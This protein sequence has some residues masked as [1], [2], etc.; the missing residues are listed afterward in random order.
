MQIL[1]V[2]DEERLAE[3]VAKRLRMESFLVDI[4][5]D[6]QEGLD[7]MI[8]NYNLIILDM[9]LPKVSGI[10][11]LNTIR[12]NGNKTPVLILTSQSD[13]EDKVDGLN[14][15]AD[16]YLTKPFSFEELL[17]RVNALLRRSA[18]GD[19]KLMIDDLILDIK[20]KEVKRG[21]DV[22]SLSATEYRL[23]EYMMRHK[24]SVLSETTLIDYVWDHNY[25]G[26]SNIVSVYMRYLR[27][28]IDRPFP[29]SKPLIHTVRGM[30]YK[31]S[32]AVK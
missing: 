32:D 30:G 12:K 17:A 18:N 4:A 9:M 28:K 31:I 1:L 5:N 15:G 8:N 29:N 24:D 16:D 7:K 11:F 23:L 3:N 19:V 22:I 26:F 6:G 27:N 20:T 10:E 14:S 2:E 21:D 13:I 25:D